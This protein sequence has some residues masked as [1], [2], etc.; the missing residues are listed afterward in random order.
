MRLG[1]ERVGPRGLLV[2]AAAGVLAAALA[3]H[4]YGQGPA[5]PVA[6]ATS[7]PT[8]VAPKTSPSSSHHPAAPT[9]TAPTGSTPQKLGPLLSSTQYASYAYQVYP[10][11]VSSQTHAA[12]AGFAVSV[13]PNGT[14]TVKLSVKANN[15]PSAQ[16]KTYPASDRV[17]FIESTFGDDSGDADYNFG[18]D[19][20][21]ITNAQGRIV[22]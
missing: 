13:V 2:L 12:L 19:G 9:T 20:V 5:V 14:G 18:D 7:P 3:V 21:L 17:Y 8:T 22:E 6:A 10:G 15:S 4:G 16:T 1:S 11:T